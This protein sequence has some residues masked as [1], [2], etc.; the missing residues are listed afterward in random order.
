[1]NGRAAGENS[2]EN[3]TGGSSENSPERNPAASA[4]LTADIDLEDRLW[5]P[6][7]TYSDENEAVIFSGTFDG[8]GHTIRGLS[9]KTA[10][11]YQGLFGYCG[12]GSRIS[13]VTAEGSLEIT[14]NDVTKIGGIVGNMV[15]GRISDV[16]SHVAVYNSDGTVHH[17]GGVAGYIWRS[18]LENCV[19]LGTVFTSG[20]DAFADGNG[21]LLLSG[22]LIGKGCG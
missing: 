22:C 5:T 4:V 8:G 15:E 20:G 10:S 12:S 6:I 13:S 9:I 14:G 16:V 17:A 2:E 1:M 18:T 7:G 3:D 11:S 21:K 19:N